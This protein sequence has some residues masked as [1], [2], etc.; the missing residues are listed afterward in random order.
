MSE[1]FQNIA[2]FIVLVL[3]G[4]FLTVVIIKMFSHTGPDERD[5]RTRYNQTDKNI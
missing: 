2:A 5:A 4:I 3:S 1:T